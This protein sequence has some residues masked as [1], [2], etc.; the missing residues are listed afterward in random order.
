MSDYVNTS[1]VGY[2]MLSLLPLLILGSVLA[3]FPTW[4]VEDDVGSPSD[5]SNDVKDPSKWDDCPSSY[6]M[7]HQSGLS[8]GGSGSFV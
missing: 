4:H 6:K 1:N 2:N 3:V 7:G 5:E 8:I